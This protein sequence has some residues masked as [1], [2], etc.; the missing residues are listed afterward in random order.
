MK[1]AHPPN[2]SFPAQCETPGPLAFKKFSGL[3]QRL[4]KSCTAHLGIVCGQETWPL[5][6]C[7]ALATSQT[8]FQQMPMRY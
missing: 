5:I 4:L 1:H 6:F 7:L 8:R 2:L 3:G